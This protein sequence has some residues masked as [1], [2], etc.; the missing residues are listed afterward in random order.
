M[1]GKIDKLVEIL[2]KEALTID[3]LE[4]LTC[5]KKA[6]ILLQLKYHLPKKDIKVIKVEK[7]GVLAYRIEEE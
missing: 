6:T 4:K 5:L 3:E 7:K 2:K 1:A